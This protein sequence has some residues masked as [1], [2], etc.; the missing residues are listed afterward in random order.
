M[1]C[2][3]CEKEMADGLERCPHCGCHYPEKTKQNPVKEEK[4]QTERETIDRSEAE[5]HLNELIDAIAIKGFAT[6]K[7]KKVVLRIAQDSGF[8]SDVVE[9]KLDAAIAKVQKQQK[10]ETKEEEN[11]SRS[12]VVEEKK[13]QK[14]PV[15]FESKVTIQKPDTITDAP[16]STSIQESKLKGLMSGSDEKDVTAVYFCKKCGLSLAPEARFCKK[17]GTKIIK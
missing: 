6:D 12:S 15:K 7:E 8:D 4:P 16:E 10:K 14:Q 13:K 2:V 9:I 1:I 3:N 5:K 11:L 17:C